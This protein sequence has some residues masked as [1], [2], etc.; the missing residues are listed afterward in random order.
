MITSGVARPEALRCDT[1]VLAEFPDLLFGGAAETEATYFDATAY[2]GKRDMYSREAIDGFIT[3]CSAFAVPIADSYSVSQD[4]MVIFNED[5]HCLV[6]ASLVYLFLAYFDPGVAVYINDRIHEVFMDGFAVSD[7]Y[8]F[9][10]HADRIPEDFL[11]L[12]RGKEDG[13]DD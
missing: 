1:V 9:R 7:T 11:K 5:G 8:L 13:D 2:L 3:S 12:N 4:R 10:K 6:S